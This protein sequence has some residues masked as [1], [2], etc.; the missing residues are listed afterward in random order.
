M[1]V[2]IYACLWLYYL[3]IFFLFL[4]TEQFNIGVKLF[5][6]VLHKYIHTYIH[7]KAHK[8]KLRPTV[9][10]HAFIHSY[11]SAHIHTQMCTYIHTYIY[12]RTAT[13][14]QLVRRKLIGRLVSMSSA[15]CGGKARFLF[16][17]AVAV[18]FLLLAP[19]SNK[20]FIALTLVKKICMYV[21]MYVCMYL[22]VLVLDVVLL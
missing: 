13:Y 1:Y 14:M 17:L 4:A 10:I 6:F 19:P 18:Q 20:P 5:R 21:C 9:Y 22:C 11:L 3:C 16:V 2:C 15:L 7:L 8:S 12:T